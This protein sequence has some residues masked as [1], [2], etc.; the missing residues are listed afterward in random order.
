MGE[1]K[2]QKMSYSERDEAREVMNIVTL[3]VI[4]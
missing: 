3:Y 2:A 4:V 1:S